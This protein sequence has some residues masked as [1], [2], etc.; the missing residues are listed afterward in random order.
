MKQEYQ[1]YKNEREQLEESKNI[2]TPSWTV[3]DVTF[4]HK[5]LKT[6]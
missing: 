4:V 2:K 6:G 5:S 3:E 1:E